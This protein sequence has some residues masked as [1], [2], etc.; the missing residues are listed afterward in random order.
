MYQVP[1]IAKPIMCSDSLN[2]PLE[3]F[4][5]RHG[6]KGENLVP[7][8]RIQIQAYEISTVCCLGELQ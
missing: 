6:D 4:E 5:H 7:T 2:T 1:S 3:K 8:S